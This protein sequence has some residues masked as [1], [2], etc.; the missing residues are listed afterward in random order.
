ME[1]MELKVL[2]HTDGNAEQREIR[3]ARRFPR[4]DSRERDIFES[5]EVWI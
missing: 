1:I 5:G 2:K 3:K 4:Q